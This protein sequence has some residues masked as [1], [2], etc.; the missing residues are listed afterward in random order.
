MTLDL[1]PSAPDQVAGPHL[2]LAAALPILQRHRHAGGVLRVAQVLGIEGEHCAAR[3]RV[4][5]QQ[6]LHLVLRQVQHRAGAALQVVADALIAGAP[7]A[8]PGDLGSGQAGRE[9]RVAHPLPGRRIAP[10]FL[11][12]AEVPKHLHGALVGDVRAGCV[13]GPVVPVDHVHTHAVGG[14]GQCGGCTHR[15]GA[16]HQDVGIEFH[17]FVLS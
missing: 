4:L 10:R 5:H 12:D 17:C 14:Q 6:R 7:G 1:A 13:R 9:Q 11:L 15:A 8:Q 2:V 16:H 3:G